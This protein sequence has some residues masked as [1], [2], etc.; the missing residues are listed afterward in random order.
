MVGYAGSSEREDS[1]ELRHRRLESKRRRLIGKSIE[2]ETGLT[3]LEEVLRDASKT[4][5]EAVL[6]F[7]GQTAAQQ[8]AKPAKPTEVEDE[9]VIERVMVQLGEP[10]P[11]PVGFSD[12]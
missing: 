3:D 9:A 7:T 6:L 12:S 4:V 1:S 10:F 11:L 5:S 8:P 2:D